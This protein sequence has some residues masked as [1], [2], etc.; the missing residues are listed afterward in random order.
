MP[1]GYYKYVKSCM[2]F[3]PIHKCCKWHLRPSPPDI[4]EDEG[5]WNSMSLQCHVWYRWKAVPFWEHY[6][7]AEQVSNLEC[8]VGVFLSYMGLIWSSLGLGGNFF[9][10]W[11]C[12]VRSQKKCR[13]FW[14]GASHT[15]YIE[16]KQISDIH[17]YND[18][19]SKPR[20]RQRSKTI[21]LT[22]LDPLAGPSLPRSGHPRP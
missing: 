3:G 12:L 21:C 15:D 10:A 5:L 22:I 7:L 2:V 17:K 18:M 13:G 20:G 4:W 9:L 6:K 19:H 1:I 16:H 14:E 8:F 11:K